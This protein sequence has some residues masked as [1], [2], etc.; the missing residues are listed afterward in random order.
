GMLQPGRNYS[1]ANGYRY[2]FNGKENDNE[3]KGEGSQQDYGMRIYDPR[4]GRF[5]SVDPLAKSYPYYTPYSYAGNKPIK[6]IDLDG[7]EEQKHWYD[8][9]INDF[10]NWLSEPSNPMEDNGFLH[11]TTTSINRNFNPLFSA[12]VLATNKDYSSSDYPRMTR[13]DAAFNLTTQIILH[14]SLS[15]A[16]AGTPAVQMEKQIIKNKLL[17]E[18]PA[19]KQIPNA[20]EGTWEI[21]N[22]TFAKPK[23]VATEVQQWQSNANNVYNGRFAQPN[24]G[25]NF[26]IDGQKI[27]GVDGIE[28]AVVKLKSDNLT[29]ANLPID[30]VVRNG[31]VYYLN[32]RSIVALTE[33]GIPKSKWIFQN[34]TGVK[35]FETNLTNNLNGSQGYM[36]TINRKTGKITKLK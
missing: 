33:A 8:Y 24:H 10:M 16:T 21:K 11:K 31:Q 22:T 9:D 28:G 15:V 12:W 23:Q 7:S 32:T 18:T 5:L 2:G 13:T 19:N 25:E 20:G 3:V 17:A 6:F 14:K 27:L 30:Y 26:S 34:Q 35:R 29:C 36:E 1:T 4:L